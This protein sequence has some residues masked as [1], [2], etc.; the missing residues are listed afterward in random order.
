MKNIRPKQS[1]GQNFLIDDNIARNIVRDLH[2]QEDDILIEIGP[3][4]GALTKHLVGK[5]KRLIAM[6]IDNRVVEELKA[7][8]ESPTVSILH[9][10]FL[11]A[12][13][14]DIKKQYRQK[15]RLIGN[16]PYHLTSSI[17]FKAFDEHDALID[18]T[19]MLQKEVARRIVA[20]PSTKDYGILA[21]LTKFYG[22]PKIFFNVSPSCFYPKPKVESSVLHIAF[23]RKKTFQIDQKLFTLIV[24][25]T[26]GKRRKTLRNGLQYLPYDEKILDEIISIDDAMMEKRPEQLTVEQFAELAKDIEK[27]LTSSIG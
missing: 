17:L 4:K 9:Q 23:H 7:L 8:Y 18:I 14:A 16:I 19:I 5:G 2:I 25:T 12:S 27:I 20:Q 15:L 26:F 11:E 22:V 3:G 21:V 13:L 24:K 1:L 6:E 10:D